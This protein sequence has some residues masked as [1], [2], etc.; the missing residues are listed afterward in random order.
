MKIR[1][2]GDF[3]YPILT[4]YRGDE[5][6][7]RF[8][9]LGKSLQAIKIAVRAAGLEDEWGGA[10]IKL[11]SHKAELHAVWRDLESSV[12]FRAIADEQW[13]AYQV[14]HEVWSKQSDGQLVRC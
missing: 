9:A 6:P 1:L 11:H 4:A 5:E 3:S 12:R 2:P 8:A 13:G 7:W 14:T 10:L